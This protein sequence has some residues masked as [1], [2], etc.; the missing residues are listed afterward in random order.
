MP[1]LQDG[2]KSWWLLQIVSDAILFGEDQLLRWMLPV[3]ISGLRFF[4][5][6]SHLCGRTGVG[7]AH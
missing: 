1:A 3:G 5:Q 6:R 4:F 7:P 2:F